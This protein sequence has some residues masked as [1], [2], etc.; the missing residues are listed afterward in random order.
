MIISLPATTGPGPVVFA[1]AGRGSTKYN[2]G[3]S[4]IFNQ[5]YHT[6]MALIKTRG[7]NLGSID[8]VL[9]EVDR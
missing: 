5:E 6:T 7:V 9:G 2:K 3:L 8:I 1:L 4:I